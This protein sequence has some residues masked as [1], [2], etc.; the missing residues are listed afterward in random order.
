VGAGLEGIGYGRSGRSFSN[1]GK[2]RLA[3]S[4]FSL[5]RQPK[6]GCSDEKDQDYIV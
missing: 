2:R 1:N 5:E 6:H 4:L 3:F